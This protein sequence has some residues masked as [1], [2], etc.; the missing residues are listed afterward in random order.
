MSSPDDED[1]SDGG[2]PT[3]GVALKDDVDPNYDALEDTSIRPCPQS[4]GFPRFPGPGHDF[5]F[6]K[7]GE[8]AGLS[9]SPGCRLVYYP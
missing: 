7:A 9:D 6:G 2:G 1:R 4:P 3:G 8:S 5:F